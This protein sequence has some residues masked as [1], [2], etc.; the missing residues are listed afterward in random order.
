MPILAAISRR[1][2]LSCFGVV[3][4]AALL[5]A[6]GCS[7]EK[8]NVERAAKPVVTRDIPSALRGVIGAEC[9]L[10]G[11]EP[12][13][14]SGFGILVGLNGTGGGYIDPGVRATMERE[15]ARGGVTRGNAQPGEIG[16]SPDE[17]LRDPNVAVV[18][19]EAAIPPG[20]PQGARFDVRVRALPNSGVTSIEGGVLWTTD[21]RIGPA[22]TM[23]GVKTRI[24]ANARGQVFINPFAEPGADGQD[25]VNRTAGRIL[26]GGLVTDPLKIELV[27]DNESHTRARA[28]VAAINTRFPEGRQDDGPTASGRTSNSIAIRVPAAFRDNATEF[29]GLLRHLSI[30]QSYPQE[31]ARKYVEDLKIYPELADEISWCLR[32]VGTPSIPFLKELYDF[33]QFGPRL[34]AL[35]AGAKLGDPRVLPHLEQIA[36][37]GQPGFRV[38]AIQL[39]SLL[40]PGSDANFTL[41]D[42][43]NSKTLD[44][45]IA[46]YEALA[47]R[48]DPMI[49]RIVV[50]DDPRLVK[51]YIDVVPAE[52]PLIYITQQGDPRIVLFGGNGTGFGARRDSIKLSKPMLVAAW[53]D[54]LLLNAPDAIAPV[55]VLYRD[56]RTGRVVKEN[57][58]PE[59][60]AALLKYFAHTPTPEN[61]EPGLG[62][63]YSETVGALYEVHRQQGVDALFAT[64]E[65]RLR[66]A[67]WD[68]A[69]VT[70]M[71]DRPELTEDSSDKMAKL[72]EPEPAQPA[73][74][75]A[76]GE[77][78]GAKPTLVQ[79]LPRK[80]KK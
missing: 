71:E 37:F 54:R 50:A 10:R 26:S 59:Q 46:A 9:T 31:L 72:Y 35:E 57:T 3:G 15:L 64:E 76:A 53:R 41:R 48:G 38:P 51:F 49:E 45:R 12:Q 34:A 5:A 11:I 30:D 1:L 44:V 78:A 58:V 29:I 75:S 20:A 2:L 55:Q 77:T 24:L 32:A 18:I 25:T 4:A 65:D 67:V 39:M 79:P 6:S 80:S 16:R 43:V 63:S 28:I 42:L 13:L 70:M 8:R 60:L 22:T 23:T 27:L 62:F 61:P 52:E 73:Q 17:F 56:L 33:P 7:N 68:A 40:P 14:V 69:K 19:V 66:A 36:Q 74:P 47:K 21:L